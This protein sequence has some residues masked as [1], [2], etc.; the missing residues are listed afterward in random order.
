MVLARKSI[1]L[2]MFALGMAT[3]PVVH[4]Q[5]FAQIQSV[6]A[7]RH[8]GVGVHNGIGRYGTGRH[9]FRNGV[10]QTGL[11]LGNQTYYHHHFHGGNYGNY[12]LAPFDYPNIVPQYSR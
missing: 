9:A 10:G 3:G 2:T 12:P 1:F 11:S 7:M 6:S 8:S 5:A 4:G